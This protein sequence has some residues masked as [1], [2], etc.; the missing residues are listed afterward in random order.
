M[1]AE[2][3]L[4]RFLAGALARKRDRYL[5]FIEKPKTR[6]KFLNAIHHELEMDLDRSKTIAALPPGRNPIPGYH[7]APPDEFGI[8]VEDLREV[9]R[10]AEDSFLAVSEDGQFGVH[11]PETL[12]DSRAIYRV[13]PT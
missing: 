12:A 5:G 6:A 10:S 11:G 13:K 3:A 8:P 9:C 4:R 2:T 1:S 7:F